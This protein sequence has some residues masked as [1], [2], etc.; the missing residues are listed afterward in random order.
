MN[1]TELSLEDI[2][3]IAVEFEENWTSGIFLSE[4][5]HLVERNASP[6]TSSFS[7]LLVEL[8]L[9]D[10]ERRWRHRCDHM[11]YRFH[12]TPGC[13]SSDSELPP[14]LNDY[15]NLFPHLPVD[16]AIL[17]Q[18]AQNEL[19]ARWR[20]GDVPDL[21][22]YEKDIDGLRKPDVITPIIKITMSNGVQSQLDLIGQVII[23][24]QAMG[25]PPPPSILDWNPKKLI[26]AKTDDITTSRNQVVVQCLAQGLVTISNKS[27]NRNLFISP[28]TNVEPGKYRVF[29][30]KT[31]IKIPLKDAIV[32]IETCK[33]I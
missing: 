19:S 33:R 15:M 1:T 13:S 31:S 23:G 10:I 25:E 26:C 28:N 7:E 20:F 14:A 2:D 30:L 21:R 18:L 29:E 3:R 24:R 32:S 17:R 12:S 6:G 8:I 5:R 9:I 11:Q 4:I 16:K 22:S 27:T